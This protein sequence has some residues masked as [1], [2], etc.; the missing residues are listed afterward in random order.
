MEQNLSLYE[1]KLQ[2]YLVYSPD[3]SQLTSLMQFAREVSTR[4]SFSYSFCELNSKIL[5]DKFET[6]E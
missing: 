6:K 5:N 2:F 1:D 4:I 3:E